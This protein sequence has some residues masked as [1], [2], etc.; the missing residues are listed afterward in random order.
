MAHWAGE[1]EFE[2]VDGEED[3]GNFV[4]TDK[5]IQFVRAHL[6]R[7]EIEE[8]ARLYEESSDAAREDLFKE[9][10]AASSTT[11]KNMARMFVVARDFG[12]AA[13]IFEQTGDWDAAARYYESGQDFSGAARCHEQSGDLHRAAAAYER[14]G[15][16]DRAHALFE[17]AGPSE[18]QATSLCRQ[19]RYAEAASVY[20]ALG[21]LRAEVE[22]LRM[23]PVQATDRLPAV[24]RLSDLLERFG[25]L[26]QAAQLLIGT[27]R[28][29]PEAQSNC[30]LLQRLVRVLEVLGRHE[31]AQAIRARIQPRISGAVVRPALTAQAGPTGQGA[32]PPQPMIEPPSAQTA[33]LIDATTES[34][35]PHDPFASLDPAGASGATSGALDPYSQ[36]KSIPIFGELGLED[37]KDLYR[38]SEQVNYAPGATVIA[39]GV[40]G[41]GLTVS[42]SGEMQV[43]RIDGGSPQ[44]LATL[45]PGSYVG[46]MALVDEGPT[47]AQVSAATP[48]RTLFISGGRFTQY[49][50]SHPDAA[51]C[52]YRL[53]TATLVD[54]LRQTNRK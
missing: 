51:L 39:Q 20:R 49:L 21:N 14:S 43:V 22:M 10:T 26:E 25:R 53:F 1:M 40:R 31:Q 19:Q 9:A 52:I 50:Y 47:S 17:Q 41:S 33:P 7:G 18:D 28:Q 15:Q 36:L 37:M 42:L 48:L 35:A 16:R 45:G 23:V 2:F 24:E 13:R 6:A 8:A 34:R 11:L 30:A 29:L 44:V 32:M 54:R 3:G 4:V 5:A 12:A 38:I 27:V 46:E